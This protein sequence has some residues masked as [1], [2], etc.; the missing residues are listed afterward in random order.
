M[1]L[2]FSPGVGAMAI[3]EN[4][5]PCAGIFF[6]LDNRSVSRFIRIIIVLSRYTIFLGV[7][8]HLDNS[9]LSQRI[10][11]SDT[12]GGNLCH[13][14]LNFLVLNKVL[15]SAVFDQA[16]GNEV[17]LILP[18][19]NIL[20][21]GGAASPVDCHAFSRCIS[22]SSTINL[23][24]T[25]RNH[26]TFIIKLGCFNGHLLPISSVL[27]QGILLRILNADETG[28]ILISDFVHPQIAVCARSIN[29]NVGST[30]HCQQP[31]AASARQCAGNINL[32]AVRLNCFRQQLLSCGVVVNLHSIVISTGCCII[33]FAGIC[34]YAI[35]IVGHNIL[36]GKC[37]L[38]TR[39][40]PIQL[41]DFVVGCIIKCNLKFLVATLYQ[42]VQVNI[43]ATDINVIACNDTA[44]FINAVILDFLNNIITKPKLGLMIDQSFLISIVAVDIAQPINRS[45][46]LVSNSLLGNI[47]LNLFGNSI[48]ELV[49]GYRVTADKQQALAVLRYR[50]LVSLQLDVAGADIGIAV[51][52]DIVIAVL[53]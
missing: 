13:T 35:L 16:P 46:S 47:A 34:A 11:A 52:V 32:T 44:G 41:A 49:L 17:L 40:V 25:A 12:G 23:R 2:G 6:I 36:I 45:L 15:S 10:G 22:S 53:N 43:Q 27:S 8:V 31:A 7:K 14:I 37:S 5:T 33:N 29:R 9:T 19:D 21:T 42:A 1:H 39:I 26:I 50:T 3:A 24:C 48:A 38:V 4:F 51:Y 18:L 30:V 28:D 20:I